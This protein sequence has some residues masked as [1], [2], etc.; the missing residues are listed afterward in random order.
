MAT[1]PARTLARMALLLALTAVA[2]QIRLDLPGG[3]PF[4]LQVFAVLLTG[5]ALPPREA[6]LTQAAYV[7]MGALGLP[8]FAG[9]RAGLGVLA[10]PTGGYLLGFPLAAA[11]T[12]AVAR[13]RD[14]L[15]GYVLGALAG[16]VPIYAL[17]VLG[18]VRHVGG[19]WSKALA[20]GV[21]PF[22]LLDA[23][24]A[25]LAAAV[26]RRLPRAA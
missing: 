6:L 22:M 12:A 8:V 23:A 3:V 14:D 10:G 20:V 15:A 18:L 13:R 25:V 24:K 17:G 19:D 16:I 5:L 4:T 2:A 21:L 26:A 7:L 11:A 9:F 1:T